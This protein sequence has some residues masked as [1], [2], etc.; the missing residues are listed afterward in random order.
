M[1]D[2]REL[3]ILFEIERRLLIEYPEL[4]QSIEAAPQHRPPDPH[5][6]TDMITTVTGLTLCLVLWIG[7]RPLTH[8]EIAT[9]LAATPPPAAA[10]GHDRD[11][12]S[13][14]PTPARDEETVCDATIRTGLDPGRPRT[15]A[16]LSCNGAPRPSVKRCWPRRCRVSE[17]AAAASA[18]PGQ[19]PGPLP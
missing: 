6:R 2:D 18:R 19:S 7:P 1:L 15:L 5:R 3:E 13:A 12:D 17:P 11:P 9:R 8:A 16:P 4:V 14:F 10:A